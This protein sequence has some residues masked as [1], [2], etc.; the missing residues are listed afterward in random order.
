MAEA[1]AGAL[2]D[3]RRPLVVGIMGSGHIEYGDGVPH[4]LA[5]LDEGDIATALPWPADAECPISDPPVADLLFG[6]ASQQ[7]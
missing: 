6:V 5:A 3:L 1:I 7:D 4:Q 2:R